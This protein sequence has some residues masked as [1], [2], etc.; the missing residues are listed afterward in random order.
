MSIYCNIK[1]CKNWLPL[2]ETHNMKHRPGFQPIGTTGEYYGKCSL[3][4]I[5]VSS[6]TAK[7]RNT[8]QVLATCDSYNKDE[9]EEFKCT[10][11]RCVFYLD[12]DKCEKIKFNED[13]YIDWTVAF[14]LEER[15]EVPRC[16]VFAHRWRENAFNWGNAAQGIF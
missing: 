14:D 5:N 11:K 6:S 13:L 8:K 9:P 12:V 16:K 2:E 7:S 10:E 15:K 3:S 1:E 4:N